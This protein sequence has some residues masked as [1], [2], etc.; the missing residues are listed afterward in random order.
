MQADAQLHKHWDQ[1]LFQ[2]TTI[3]SPDKLF[4]M[5]LVPDL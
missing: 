2:G 4:L 3:K 5:I 1:L